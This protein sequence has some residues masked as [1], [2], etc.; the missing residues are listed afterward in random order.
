V[1]RVASKGQLVV[2]FAGDTKALESASGKAGKILGGFAKVA[3]AAGLAAGAALAAG[4]IESMNIEKANDKL[5]AQLGLSAKKSKQIGKVAGDLYKDAYGDSIEGVN[6]AVG[7]VM[8]SIDGMGKASGKRLEST[9]AKALDFATAMDVD[10]TRAAQVA[11]Q[12]M[13]T[14]LAKNADQAFD[15]I[16]AASQKVPASLREDV[17]DAADEYGQFFAGLGLSGEEAFG[18]LV[19]GAEKGQF[20][21]DKI[22][23]AVKEFTIRSTDM[24]KTSKEAYTAIGLD[25]NDMANKI[26]K[27]GRSAKG[28]TK[29]IIGGLLS[30]KDP[31]Q[32]ANAAIALF[33]TPIEDLNVKDIPDFLKSLQGAEGGLGKVRGAAKRMGETLNGNAAT[34]LEAFKRT[35][36]SGVVDFLGKHVLPVIKDVIG[37]ISRHKDIFGPLAIALGVV[38]V[39]IGIVTVATAAWSAVLQTTGIPLLIIGIAALV[40]GLVFFFTKTKVGTKIWKGFTSFLVSAWDVVKIGLKAAWNWIQKWV[41][42]PIFLYVKFLIAVF[43]FYGKIIG[44]I[45]RA[46]GSALRAVWN[47]IK[48]KVFVPIKRGIQ[49][50]GIGFKVYGQVIRAAWSKV[51]SGLRSVWNWIKKHVFSPVANFVT[52]TIPNAF[53]TGVRKVGEW[54][55]GLKKMAQTPVKFLVN[56][57]WNNGLRKMLNAIPGVDID[58]VVLKF[59]QGGAVHGGVAGKDSV[60]ALMMPGEH[61]WTAKEVRAAGGQQQMYAMRKAV[62]NGNLNGDP[63][64]ANGGALSSDAIARAQAFA[65]AQRG[66]PY[67]WGAVGPSAYDCSGFMSAITNVLQGQSPHRRRGATADFPWGGFQKGPGQFTIGSTS[68]YAGSGIGHMVGNLAGLGVESRG[69]RGVILGSGAMNPAGAAFSKLYHLGAAGAAGDASGGWLETISDVLAKLKA[70]PGQIREMMSGGSWITSFLKKLASGLWS[71]IAGFLNKKIPDFGPIPT[72]FAKGGI[73]KARPGGMHAIVGEGGYDEAIIPLA[74]PHAPR[75]NG[76]QTVVLELRS[77]GTKVDDMLLAILRDAIKVRG[78]DPVKVLTRR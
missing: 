48:D 8:T 46:L 51:G 60:R 7:A 15:L 66:K 5:S 37:F 77:S 74:G 45:W 6:T 35:L 43:K 27:G 36:Q 1:I 68:N 9:T 16:T 72:K 59:A 75:R 78:N 70:L 69:G 30:I 20:G 76:Q 49:L 63:K 23:D 13:R 18:M 54:W 64:F 73:V 47:W 29:D 26:L 28:A 22:G 52:K 19:K 41:F 17:L 12:V 10:V 31:A 39:A 42:R 2:R 4:V 57:V 55:D 34:D 3:G 50:V 44:I 21:L 56:T 11:G 65:N 24:S 38:A 14:G 53:R 33:G 62:L 61:V 32:Q 71:N 67:G 58:P 25:A 40:A